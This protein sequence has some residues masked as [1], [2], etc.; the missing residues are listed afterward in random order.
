MTEG[1]SS[2]PQRLRRADRLRKRYEFRR[3][4]LDGRRIHTAHF[5]I[6]VQPNASSNTRLGITVTKKVG[7][8]VQRNRIKRVVREA[9]RRNRELFPP[10]HDV[11]LIAKRGAADI[12]YAALLRELREVSRRL[13][14]REAR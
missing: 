7:S 6:V 10:N 2:E 13:R 5:L 12:D 11:V 14:P 8:A 9:F 4:Q 3:A 1:R